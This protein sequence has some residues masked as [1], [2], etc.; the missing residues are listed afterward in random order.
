[1]RYAV[2]ELFQVRML[3]IAVISLEKERRDS[4]FSL[5][6]YGIYRSSGLKVLG[7]RPATQRLQHRCFPLNFVIFLKEYLFLNRT[8]PVASSKT[9]TFHLKNI[10]HVFIHA[11]PT[12][13]S[14]VVISSEAYK[15]TGNVGSPPSIGNS[16]IAKY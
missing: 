5:K 11:K 13:I 2:C 4:V 8:P 12:R 16:F 10:F 9:F 1:M 7:A 14:H 15:Y 6:C 3:N